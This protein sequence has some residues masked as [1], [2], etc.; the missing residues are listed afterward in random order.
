MKV[1]AFWVVLLLIF[2]LVGC[3]GNERIND[4]VHHHD[5]L[6]DTLA[7]ERKLRTRLQMYIDSVLEVGPAN[8][9][10][11][12][13]QEA[14]QKKRVNQM[15]ATNSAPNREARLKALA[16]NYVV[17]RNGELLHIIIP[18]EFLFDKDKIELSP[19]GR[20][21]AKELADLIKK[22]P[23][24]MV[25]VE[26]HMD[27]HAQ[28]AESAPGQW[29]PSVL[30]ATA[31]VRQ[32]VLL[33]VS[34]HRLRAAGRGEYVAVADNRAADIRSANRRVELIFQPLP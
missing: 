23:K 32:L 31:L 5:R 26:G 19:V 33:G 21:T 11:A 10:V 4:L 27:H 6:E 18:E 13:A 17:S 12:Q 15:K 2:A 28:N 16:K 30:R 34:P 3:S 9:R 22:V 8:V 7:M 24:E 1:T 14:A 25:T 20:R 29:E